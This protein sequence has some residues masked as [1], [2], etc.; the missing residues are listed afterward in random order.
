MRGK[1]VWAGL[2]LLMFAGSAAATSVEDGNDPLVERG[3]YLVKIAGCNDCHTPDYM[4]L[5][6]NVPEHQWLTGEALG[7]RGPWGTTYGSNLRLFFQQIDE[8]QWL[9]LARTVEY[10]PPMPWFALRAM[11]EED[12]RA[13]YRY[14]DQAGPA[15]DPAPAYLPPGVEPEGPYAQF[16]S[17]PKD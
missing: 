12:L 10:R 14:I 16:P 8:E 3:R 9:T 2:A 1:N 7:W 6:G 15:G 17:P 5:V 11:T 4:A 13:I